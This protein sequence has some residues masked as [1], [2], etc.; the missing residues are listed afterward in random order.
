MLPPQHHT[1]WHSFSFVM[2]VSG[3]KFEEHCSSKDF[4]IGS[5]CFYFI[6]TLKWLDF[7]CLSCQLTLTWGKFKFFLC[8]ILIGPFKFPALQSYAREVPTPCSYHWLSKPRKSENYRNRTTCLHRNRNPCNIAT[9]QA[10]IPQ[11]GPRRR[12]GATPLV[13]CLVAFQPNPD[14][15]HCVG[16]QTLIGVYL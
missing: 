14:S 6:G 15:V 10:S 5:N 4:Q 8:L 16:E 1:R 11:S 2:Y 7:Q 12:Y 9:V 13:P 3:A